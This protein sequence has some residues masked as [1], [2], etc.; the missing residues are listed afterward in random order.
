MF[1]RQSA[2]VNLDEKYISGIQN[3]ILLQRR[4]EVKRRA[5]VFQCNL[6]AFSRGPKS[7]V[8]PL[9]NTWKHIAKTRLKYKITD[10]S[11][12]SLV[13][14]RV[15][16]AVSQFTVFPSP[17]PN[18]VKRVE[19]IQNDSKCEQKSSVLS[20]FLCADYVS[21]FTMIL[22]HAWNNEKTLTFEQKIDVFLEIAS[23]FSCF[24]RADKTS[25]FTVVPCPT[26]NTE[27]TLALSGKIAYFCI[28]V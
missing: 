10:I 12:K 18:L 21:L 3:A 20:C 6:L 22:H 27:K 8:L 14:S 19:C 13:F 4:C 9:K 15:L 24:L 28:K 26:Q 2:T 23:V 11:Y 1:L 5:L 16:F 17:T 7:H 25:I